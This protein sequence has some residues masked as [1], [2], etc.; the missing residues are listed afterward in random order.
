MVSL[1]DHG[2][3]WSMIGWSYVECWVD[4]VEV[5]DRRLPQLRRPLPHEFPQ[6]ESQG[7]HRMHSIGCIPILP[8]MIAPRAPATAPSLPDINSSSPP[9]LIDEVW[10]P[11]SP[12]SHG[13]VV[14]P[15]VYPTRSQTPGCRLVAETCVFQVTPESEL[16]VRDI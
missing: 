1:D 10:F 11:P 6:T 4:D 2:E 8:V 12:E 16:T 5:D 7:I 9:R 3:V 13:K 15:K 14:S